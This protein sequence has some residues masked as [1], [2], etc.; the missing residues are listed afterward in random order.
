MRHSADP[1]IFP[2][3]HKI[4]QKSSPAGLPKGELLPHPGWRGEC[5]DVHEEPDR[6]LRGDA[7]DDRG[8]F[9]CGRGS[10]YLPGL[11]IL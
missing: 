10:A 7:L 1:L 4:L 8:A 6:V 11:G 9:L 5:A 2:F 3:F